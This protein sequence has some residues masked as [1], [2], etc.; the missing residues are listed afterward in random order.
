MKSFKKFVYIDIKVL[1]FK[2]FKV[3]CFQFIENFL[4]DLEQPVL[5]M[6]QRSFLP[7]TFFCG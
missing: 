6:T 7:N 4:G 3:K 2:H 1:V 5:D